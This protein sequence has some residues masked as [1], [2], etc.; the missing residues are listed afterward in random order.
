M[1]D[2]NVQD[3]VSLKKDDQQN[4]VSPKCAQDRAADWYCTAH[5]AVGLALLGGPN[6]MADLMDLPQSAAPYL[7]TTGACL[8]VRGILLHRLLARRRTS[9]APNE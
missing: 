2:E 5:E 6:I 1:T 3:A 4:A 9:A 8:L 7:M